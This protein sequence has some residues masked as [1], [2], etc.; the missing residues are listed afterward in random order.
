MQRR[1]R[2]GEGW[3]GVGRTEEELEEGQHGS[4]LHTSEDVNFTA[5]VFKFLHLGGPLA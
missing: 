1:D 4:V 3:A 5:N 2:R